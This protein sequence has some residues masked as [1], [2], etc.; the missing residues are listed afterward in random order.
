MYLLVVAALLMIYGWY[1]SNPLLII[2]GLALVIVD[3]LLPCILGAARVE[4]GKSHL[5]VLAALDQE[6]VTDGDVAVINGF[7]VQRVGDKFRLY[8]NERAG[9]GSLTGDEYHKD[10]DRKGYIEVAGY[11]SDQF[12]E[13]DASYNGSRTEADARAKLKTL[14]TARFRGHFRFDPKQKVESL[15]E[16]LAFL[17]FTLLARGFGA[18]TSGTTANHIA[19]RNPWPWEL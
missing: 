12:R 7:V 6:L 14:S 4:G 11:P 19:A 9:D 5:K 16:S 15:T 8:K 10:V 1:S 18:L 13:F 2:A 17:P 3:M